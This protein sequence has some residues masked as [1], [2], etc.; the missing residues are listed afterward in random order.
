MLRAAFAMFGVG[1]FVGFGPPGEDPLHRRDVDDVFVTG[2]LAKHQRLQARAQDEGRHRVDEVDLEHLGGRDV[3]EGQPPGVHAAQVDL[4]EVRVRPAGG[5]EVAAPR[6]VALGVGDLRQ[7]RRSGDAEAS[8]V[9]GPGRQSRAAQLDG[10]EASLLPRG[11]PSGPRGSP[12]RRD[13][14][15]E[16]RKRVAI[17]FPGGGRRSPAA[18]A[19][20]GRRC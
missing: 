13:S 3:G 2:R 19:R 14:P 6:G 1:V 17:R 11:R 10:R 5:E 20:S 9:A 18:A 15:R 12:A 8:P 16:G 7:G 4:L